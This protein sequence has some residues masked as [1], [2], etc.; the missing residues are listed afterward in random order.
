MTARSLLA[1]GIAALLFGAAPL[2][3]RADDRDVETSVHASRVALGDPITLQIRLRGAAAAS[4]P[5]FAP[6][7][8]DFE[9][10]DVHQSHRTSIINGEI[11]RS[12]DYLVALGA[13]REGDLVIPALP[14]GSSSTEPMS[15]SVVASAGEADDDATIDAPTEPVLVET[16]IDRS[17]PYEQER[18]VLRIQLYAAG[19][20][21]EGALSAP[22]IPGAVIEV[23]G[24]DRP[25]EKQIGGRR[26]GGIERTYTIVPEA[27][28]DLVVP[29]IR[30]EG[31]VRVPR[32]QP[33]RRRLGGGAFG[34]SLLEDFFANTPRAHALLE[35]FFG[36]ES[37][38]IAAT[39][40][41]L[42]LSVRPRPEGVAGQ[43]W[44]P[45]RAVSLS[46]HW[47]P[48]GASV[49][50]GEPITRRI[51]IRADGVSPA[52]VP[53]LASEDVAGVKQYAEAP[54]VTENL[55]GT[56]R[57]DETT[58]I[59]TQPGSVTL[60]AIEIAWWDTKADALRTATLPA[61]DIE[62]TP[63]AGGDAPLGAGAAPAPAPVA[64]SA[65]TPTP[66][67]ALAS[68]GLGGLVQGFESRV[69]IALIAGAALALF[70][71]G[72]VVA[73]LWQ[74]RAHR[75]ESRV[76][77]PPA[78]TR[79]AL[80]RALRR[81]CARKDVVAA[82]TALRGLRH[83]LGGEAAI[84]GDQSVSQEI[85]RLHAVRYSTQGDVWSG[86]ALWNAWRRARKVRRPAATS[87]GLPP[88]Y[89]AP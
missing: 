64:D 8:R 14:V 12:V 42:K 51:E 44:L 55:R 58:L 69:R 60:P 56:V 76:A 43:W 7:A 32:P 18:V 66:T 35:N 74:R 89:P 49:R 84:F 29:G 57:V 17:D 50:V 80:E 19:E 87:T 38:R 85:A 41:P 25:I 27:S 22:E 3:A 59:P 13:R 5:D 81:A 28:G 86:A 65:P 31:R 53:A 6:L 1:L 88:L 71:L 40:K 70:L 82:E 16:R 33:Q 52:Q 2:V 4:E 39:S 75:N 83:R 37:R 36:T 68:P 15:I 30:F 45:A 20:V 11:D 26:Y 67:S 54:K 47:D 77:D 34:G 48:A 73:R 78:P 10:L 9:V 62:V 24:E 79:R 21:L 23:I 72:I 61:R 46:E 63:V